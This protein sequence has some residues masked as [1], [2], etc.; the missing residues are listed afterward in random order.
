MKSLYELQLA[1]ALKY[2]SN[3]PIRLVLAMTSLLFAFSLAF[4]PDAIEASRYYSVMFSAAPRWHW[5]LMFTANS[6]AMWWRIFSCRSRVGWSRIINSWTFALY[7]TVVYTSSMGVGYF[8]P[9]NSAELMLCLMA[10]WTAI[11]TD[12]TEGDRDTA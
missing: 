10:L 2:S 7:L 11:R 1:Q 9:G 12:L 4:G 8:L 5:V 6:A 3:L